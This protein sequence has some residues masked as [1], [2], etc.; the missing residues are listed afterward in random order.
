M[1]R[2]LRFIVP[3]LPVHIVQ[4][5]NNRMPCFQSDEDRLVY[6]SLVRE[7]VRSTGC[8]LHA[9]CLMTNHVHLMMTPPDGDACSSLM[10]VLSHRYALYFNKKYQ[11]TGGLWEGRFRSC[12]VESSEYILACHRYIELNPV[13]AGMVC[14]AATYPWSSQAV[15]T[16]ANADPLVTTHPVILAF[17]RAAYGALLSDGMDEDLLCRIRESTH[18]G[19]PLATDSFKS[20]WD[21]VARRRMER[22]RSGRKP[23]PHDSNST[24]G[25]SVSDTDLFSGGGV[26]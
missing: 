15:N 18:G 13:R 16:G 23:K 3:D 20:Q 6:L 24:S 26:S 8:A 11:R 1:A 19:Y 4:R 9:Y 5:G 14:T 7:L 10:K 21:R 25:K 2:Q 22:S 12:L 17:G